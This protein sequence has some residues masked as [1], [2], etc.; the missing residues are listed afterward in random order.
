MFNQIRAFLLSSTIIAVLLFS[1]VGTTVAYADGGTGTPPIDL[2][3]APSPEGASSVGTAPSP[4]SSTEDSAPIL[5]SVPDNTAVTVLNAEG[6][7]EP[8]ASQNAANAVVTSDPFWCPETELVPTPGINNCTTSFPSFTAL[9]TF[10]SGNSAYQGAGVIYVQQ[11]AYTGPEST[12]NFNNFNLS[13]LEPSSLTITGG[14]ANNAPD[15]NGTSSFNNVSLVIGTATNPWGGSLSLNNLTINDPTGTGI[16]LFA[17]DDAN[18]NRINVT[19]STNGAGAELHAGNDVNINNSSFLRNRTAGAI[20][21]SVRDTAVANSTFSNP[22]NARRQ[23]VGLDIGAGRNVSLLN[24][25]AN[26]NRDAGARINA[27]D[28]VTIG[29]SEFSGT[30]A[31]NGSAFIGE[32]LTVVAA[33][34]IDLNNVK[35]NNNF[36]WGASLRAGGEV[37]IANSEFNGNTTE[38][39]GFIDDTGLL[40]TTTNGGVSLLNVK[41][42]DNRLLGATINATGQVTI[43]NSEFLSNNGIVLD[44]AGNEV[45][46]GV[47]L[48]VVTLGE[49]FLDA[50]NASG[51]TFHGAL[52]DAGMD[53][54]VS[55]ST[56]SNNTSL[57]NQSTGTPP[58]TGKGLVIISDG[59]VILDTVTLDGNQT[60]GASIQAGGAVFLDTV[61]A[62]NNGTNG[63]EVMANCTQVFLIGGTYTGNG[64]YGLSIVNGALNQIAPPVF[65][66]N[67]AGDIFQDPGTCIFTTTTTEPLIPPVDDGG[68]TPPTGPGSPDG[69]S[70]VISPSGGASAATT[71]K[72]VT[73]SA[74]FDFSGRTVSAMS[75]TA[76]NSL[77]ANA[78]LGR[79]SGLHVGLFMGKPALIYYSHGKQ[80]I[81][82]LPAS[83]DELAMGG[84]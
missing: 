67:G 18:L 17:Q 56:F 35:A 51:N 47:G 12:V 63:V 71:S 39:P 9:L 50:V 37:A 80:I 2:G 64:Q 42:N 44:S 10:L 59:N 62:T 49:I 41:A 84:S 78:R 32:G 29:S 81:I 24:V 82:F 65:G 72:N 21:Q 66:G 53:V 13:N 76:L 30:K 52:L 69:G 68:T 23:M 58:V 57:N 15:P 77:L 6:Q 28:R 61:T 45:F 3:T 14:W 26:E 8:L 11:G 40:V 7:P 16:T 46:H 43:N 74:A 34:A 4:D 31:M 27:G 22:V 54:S 36:L 19:N 5:D 73:S 70:S 75:R 79:G 33:G 83:L 60:F 20:I 1:A 38:S 25:L 55:N 48:E